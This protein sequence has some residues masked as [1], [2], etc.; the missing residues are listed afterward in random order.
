MAPRQQVLA[1]AHRRVRDSVDVWRERLCDIGDSHAHTVGY[2]HAVNSRYTVTG[3]RT[4]SDI[5]AGANRLVSGLRQPDQAD[6][7]QI[8]E[9]RHSSLRRNDDPGSSARATRRIWP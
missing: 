9:Y 5:S 1:Y 4:V 7:V 6:L 3:Q 8:S 2:P